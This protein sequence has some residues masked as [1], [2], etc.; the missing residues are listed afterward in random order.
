MRL[1]IVTTVVF[2]ISWNDEPS[3]LHAI[4]VGCAAGL[5]I[6]TKGSSYVYLPF[7]VLACWWMGTPAARVR[8]LKWCWVFL[9]FIF[10]LNAPQ[11][12]RCYGLTG[13]PLDCARAPRKW[14]EYEGVGGRA[15][16]FDSIGVFHA[17][18]AQEN[19]GEPPTGIG[20]VR[21]KLESVQP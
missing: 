19:H 4:L 5:A 7:I 11:Y 1:W 20:T 13:S 8:W 16:V 6:L 15:S 18:G 3:P 21:T 12:V 10:A 14:Q 17:Q 2:L 9:I